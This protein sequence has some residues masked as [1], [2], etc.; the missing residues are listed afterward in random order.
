MTMTL[1]DFMALKKPP[2]NYVDFEVNG[3]ARRMYGGSFFHA[4]E[5]DKFLTINLMEEYPLPCDFYLPIKDYSCP[6]DIQAMFDIFE[7]IEKSNK[8][9]YVGCFGGVGRT[10]LFM[11]CF[12]KHLG[13]INPILRVR[14][15]YN[16]HAVE[17]SEQREFVFF[18][19]KSRPLMEEQVGE[20][21]I[22]EEPAKEEP[23]DTFKNKE[24]SSFFKK[25]FK[26]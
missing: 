15:D 22:K 23:E 21:K 12:L 2:E 6:T 14:E 10:G 3:V 19:P 16:S 1:A 24:E 8:D 25:I 20:E 17:T 11:S 9:V 26:L 13:Q 18:F 5:D 7:E 4:P